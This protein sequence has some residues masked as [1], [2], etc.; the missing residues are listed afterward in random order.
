MS[1]E[2]KVQVSDAVRYRYDESSQRSEVLLES[3]HGVL[4]SRVLQ[5]GT[6]TAVVVRD[7]SDVFLLAKQGRGCVLDAAGDVIASLAELD[8]I[9]IPAGHAYRLEAS[10]ESEESFRVLEF[11]AGASPLSRNYSPFGEEP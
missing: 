2:L 10:A 1:E 8:G 5:P 11:H 3:D 6:S 4:G 9:V 7:A